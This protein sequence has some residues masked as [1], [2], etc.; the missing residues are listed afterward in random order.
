MRHRPRVIAFIVA[1]PVDL[2]N[3]IGIASVFAYP[4]IDSKPA[5]TLKILSANNAPEVQGIGGIA[6]SNGIPFSD[7]TGSI[8]TLIAVSGEGAMGELSPDLFHWI[9]KRAA[10]VRRIASVCTGAFMLA[11]T[12]LL[13]GKRVTTHWHHVDKLA[14]Q[15]PHLRIEKDPIFIRDGNVYT[16][17]GVTAGIDL[18]L[19]FVE[20][21]LGDKVAT[22]IARELVLYM[23]R[24]GN[25]AQFSTLLAQQADVSGTP[26]R[27][28]P[29]WA[30]GRLNQR[31][32]VNA[33]AKA[34][35]MTPRTFARQF[36]THF[37][38]TPARWIQSLRVEAACSHLEAQEL[39]VKAIAKLTGFR[40]EQSLRRAFVQQLSMTPK[41]YRERFGSFMASDLRSS[42]VQA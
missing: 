9:R 3:L 37:Q 14:K 31:L 21:D 23:R 20:E 39:P 13:D 38:T 24:P 42:P 5:Y 18:A 27:S 28:L 32:D 41:E 17:A 4:T 10:R 36:E 26:M 7:Y 16:T 12:G 33:M 29:A 1:S 25:E 6:I 22:D 2:L 11:P 30:K 8:D 15:F 35:A 40:D 34:V 19:G